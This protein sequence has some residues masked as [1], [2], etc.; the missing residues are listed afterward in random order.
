MTVYLAFNLPTTEAR[1]KSLQD[2]KLFSMQHVGGKIQL[3]LN[4]AVDGS[5]PLPSLPGPGPGPGNQS[6]TLHTPHVEGWV[7]PKESL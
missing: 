6:P 5:R 4:L 2:L 3:F 7:G 1:V